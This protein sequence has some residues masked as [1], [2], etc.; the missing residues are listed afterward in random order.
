MRLRFT[1]AVCA[2]GVAAV[3][4]LVACLAVLLL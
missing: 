2:L 3:G 1:I 4:G